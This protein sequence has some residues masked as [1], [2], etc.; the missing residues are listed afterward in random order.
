VKRADRQETDGESAVGAR[1]GCGRRSAIA[2]STPRSTWRWHAR[3]TS[4]LASR[5]ALSTSAGAQGAFYYH[6]WP[7]VYLDEGGGRGLWL[8]G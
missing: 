6:A 1:R 7:E 3:F 4:R 8:A 5:S 2:T